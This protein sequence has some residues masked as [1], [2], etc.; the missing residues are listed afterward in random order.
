MTRAAKA[1]FSN[2]YSDAARAASYATLEFPGTYYL[3]FRDLPALFAQHV[4]GTS[5]IDFGC[6]TGR[7]TRFLGQLGFRTI[8][9]D[10]SAEM[11]ALAR[12]RDPGGDYVVIGD[13]DLAPCPPAS[14]DLALCMF[15]FDNIPGVEHRVHL[16]AELRARL[17]PTGTLVLVDSTPELYTHEW[18]SF[19]TAATYPGNLRASS[20]DLV[21]T[22][23]LD[24]PDRRPVADVLWLDEDYRE[25]FR[26]AGLELVAAHRPLGTR[27][28][29]FPWVNE[30]EIAPWVIYV[31]RP[32]PAQATS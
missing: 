15:T 16:L 12:S 9:L 1:S 13:G 17:K 19:S 31:T 11:V 5:A 8:G 26:R 14:Y 18:T 21:Y 32:A 4:T 20:G 30:T 27:D 25:A 2:V 22:L 7:S 3:A 24:V 28:E 6:G 10:I 29:P 23:M